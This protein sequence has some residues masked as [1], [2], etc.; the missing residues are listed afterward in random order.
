MRIAVVAPSSRFS[1][2]A[3]EQVRSI[4]AARFPQVDLYFHPQCF[5]ASNHF[6]G[7]DRERAQAIVEMAN[8]PTVDAIW[9]ARGGYGACRIADQVLAGL[10]PT[11][12]DKAFMGYS[13]GGYL[14]AGLYRHGFPHVAHGPMAQDV[15]RDGGEAAIV[16]ALDWLVRRSFDSLEPELTVGKHHAAFNL[17][18]LG[19]LLGT[20]LQPDLSDHVLLIEEVSEHMYRTDR[21]MFHLT[22]NPAMRT[23]AGIRL[24]RCNDILANDPDFGESEE[25]VVQFWCERS[26]I[27]YLGRADIGH[28]ACNRIVPF[29]L[30][31]G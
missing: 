17:T 21:A 11:A 22:G 20:P 7:P 16:R 15:L 29:G 30:H 6:A 10:G 23:L 28:D 25:A 19:L 9:F 2:Q 26:G 5:L 27:P 8:D 24:G 14:L 4:A 12:R 3:A 31:S 1:E 18:V 13:D